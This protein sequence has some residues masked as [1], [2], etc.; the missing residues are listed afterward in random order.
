MGAKSAPTAPNS[1]ITTDE[2]AQYFESGYSCDNAIL[3]KLDSGVF[4][5][6]DSRYTT[7]A[8]ENLKQGV[9]L[10]ESH[11]LLDSAIEILGK[12]RVKELAFDP[13]MLCVQDFERLS[14]KLDKCKLTPAPNFHQLKRIIKSDEEIRLIQK[15]QQ[16]NK[17]AYKKFAKLI[18]K[19]MRECELYALS[20]NILE[21]N[22]AYSLSFNPILGINANA[23]KPH[24]LPSEVRLRHGD[25]ILFDAGIKYKR[26]CSDRTRT[27]YFSSKGLSFSKD[28][29]FKDK[30]LQ[31]IYDIVRKAQEYAIMNLR[32][33]MSGK[34]IDALARGVIEK[35]GFGEYFSH[36]TGH[37]IGLDIHELPF[38]STR[39]DMII[40]DGMVFSIEPGIYI[41]G[42][43]GVRIEDLVV[44]R[45]G[46]AEIL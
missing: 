11:A 4:F 36:S 44:V 42:K 8:R 23:A 33:G 25:L 30:H 45:N 28:Q 10:I 40:E 19:G 14:S 1:F 7:E 12:A 34:E 29:R 24:A 35:A 3:L 41:P 27:A 17:K 31:K 43:Y 22:G 18:Q 20:K 38:I 46:K 9:Q 13:R 37:G 16:L 21:K 2:S 6:T 32:A 15:S 5:I 26:Y 39:S